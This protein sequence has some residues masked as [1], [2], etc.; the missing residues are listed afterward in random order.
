MA[1]AK[2]GTKGVPRLER[3]NQMLEVA[4]EIFGNE[5]YAATNIQ[6]VA[7]R[8]GISKPLIYNYF[9]SREGLLSACL[10]H[11]AEVIVAEIERSAGL[12]EVGLSRALVTLDGIFVA[13][14]D[15]PWI[16]TLVN[17]PTLGSVAE[18]ADVLAP[19]RHKVE[20]LAVD[21]VGELMHLAGDDD[22]EDVSAMVAVWSSVFDALV[23]WW[24]AHPG[25][26]AEEMSARCARL[27]GAVFGAILAS[28]EPVSE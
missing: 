10:G 2:A 11:A 27:F 4:S 17:D 20:A 18:V 26:T 16:W 12:G 8:A 3:E 22:E 7:E 25:T 19:Y 5:G 6:V 1:R 23:T 28:A 21:G 9:G 13:L 14:A 24:V 15:R